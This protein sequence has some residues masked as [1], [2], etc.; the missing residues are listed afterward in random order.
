MVQKLHMLIGQ[1]MSLCSNIQINLKE[2]VTFVVY[3]Q[4]KIKVKWLS[5]FVLQW[6]HWGKGMETGTM[7][8]NKGTNSRTFYPARVHARAEFTIIII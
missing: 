3:I 8:L 7:N 6:E 2:G 1:V 4:V 5:L